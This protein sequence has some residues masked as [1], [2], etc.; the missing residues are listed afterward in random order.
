MLGFL[1][2]L[3]ACVSSSSL[4]RVDELARAT[5]ARTILL[6]EHV[7]LYSPYDL[8]R[9]RGYL[10]RVEAERAAV[11]ELFGVESE[12]PIKVWLRV[13]PELGVHASIEGDRMRIE[14]VSFET[15]D[16]ILGE[17]DRGVVVI[18]VAPLDVVSLPDGRTITGTFDVSM[19]AD[20]IRHE[21]AHVAAY[22]LGVGGHG[23]LQEGLAHVVQ[24][25][26]VENGR[27]RMDPL[28]EELKVAAGMPAE[29]R[30]VDSLLAWEQSF[31]PTDE[32]RA[33]RLLAF[34]FLAFLIEREGAPFR[35]AVLRIAA[36]DETRVRVFQDAWSDW[37]D[38]IAGAVRESGG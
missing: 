9:T 35:E 6:E 11:F 10:E 32:D 17:A 28:P 15:H 4:E 16:G 19:Y 14:S 21:L 7:S 3:A 31:P 18:R 27:L 2:G 37:L 29:V 38:G 24:W 34:S 1:G 12:Q 36:L 22:L 20:T 30:S 26:P 33:A 5:G 8:L 13:D 23:W 25:I